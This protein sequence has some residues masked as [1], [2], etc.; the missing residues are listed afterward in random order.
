MVNEWTLK[1][2]SDGWVSIRFPGQELLEQ[3]ETV[4]A[5]TTLPP[6]DVNEKQMAK[7][8]VFEL[9][10]YNSDYSYYYTTSYSQIKSQILLP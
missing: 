5:F 6:F 10:I 3:L 7:Q 8:N 4:S 2:Y 9:R 1:Y